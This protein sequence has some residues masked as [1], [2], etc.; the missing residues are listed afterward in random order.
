[1]SFLD[2]N[3]QTTTRVVLEA[4]Y[5]PIRNVYLRLMARSEGIE[6]GSAND[7]HAEIRIGLRVGAY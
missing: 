3:L 1:V 5:E 4:E 7:R 6:A 2:G